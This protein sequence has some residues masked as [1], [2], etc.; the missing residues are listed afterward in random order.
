MSFHNNVFINCPFD[1]K[2]RILLRPLLFSLLYFNLNPNLSETASSSD[3]RIKNIMRLI[4]TSKYSIHDISRKKALKR[5]DVAR[6]NM[7]YEMGLDIGCQEFGSGIL[8]EKKCL[9]FDSNSHDY[10]ISISDISAQDI[11][12]HNDDPE[13][14]IVK[15]REWFVSLLRCRLPSAATVWENYTEFVTDMNEQLILEGYTRKEI[16][17]L[18]HSEFIIIATEWIEESRKN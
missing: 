17:L 10:D 12:E 13:T 7:S 8:K 14:L 5:G 9:I 2:Y 18:S 11:K 3:I 1:D 15:V 6:F 16:E 4:K